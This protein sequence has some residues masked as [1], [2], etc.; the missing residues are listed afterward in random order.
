MEITNNPFQQADQS[1]PNTHVSLE[2]LVALEKRVGRARIRRRV[3][4]LTSGIA[5]ILIALFGSTTTF[6]QSA[7][8]D[9]PLYPVKRFSESFIIAVIPTHQKPFVVRH[10]IDRRIEEV[11]QRPELVSLIEADFNNL[12]RIQERAIANEPL[13]EAIPAAISQTVMFQRDLERLRLME[14]THAMARSLAQLNRRLLTGLIPASE[15][16]EYET[17]TISFDPSL[18]L[19]MPTSLPTPTPEHL[20]TD[21]S[22]YYNLERLTQENTPTIHSA[23]LLLQS[24]NAIHLH[25]ISAQD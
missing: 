3:F 21:L 9:S 16:A 13:P 12:I 6:A 7:L 4:K 18:L 2:W 23:L 22:T 8:P 20:Q 19:I 17:R 10:L 14:E 11:K 5:T 15:L 25:L 1:N 24:K